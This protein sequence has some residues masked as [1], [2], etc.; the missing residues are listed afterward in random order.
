VSMPFIARGWRTPTL[1]VT[2]ATA[3]PW[4]QVVPVLGI[5]L[6][7]LLGCYWQTVV[8]MAAVWWRSETY[9]HGM[10]VFPISLYM[11]WKRRHTLTQLEP[12]PSPL[13]VV[14]LALAC[15]GWLAA[16]TA[17]VLVV[18]QFA[19]VTMLLALIYTLLGWQLSWAIAFPLAYLYFAVPAGEFLTPPLQ[20]FTALFAVKLLRLT[21]L[22]VFWEGYRISIPTGEFEV[23][24]A[25]S[26]LRYLIASLAL[27]CLYAYLTYRSLWRR[28]AF[29]AL[30]IVVPIIANGV[31]AYGIVMIAYLSN[32]RLATGVDHIIYGWLFFGLVV[33]LMFWIGSF[34][35]EPDRRPVLEAAAAETQPGARRADAGVSSGKFISAAAASLLVA[36]LGPAGE[37]WLNAD[38]AQTEAVVLP[39]PAATPPWSGPSA[40]DDDWQ[41]VFTGADAI[42]QRVYHLENRPVHLYI[43]FYRYQ[44]PNAK[45]VTTAN[46][47]YDGKRWFYAGERFR[48]VP[49]ASGR[50]QLVETRVSS[51][52]RRRLIWHWYWVAGRTTTSPV[53]TKM[54]EA[55]DRLG[56]KHQ[57]SALVAVAADYESSPAEAEALLTRFLD[58]MAGGI[59][60]TLSRQ[61]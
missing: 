6:L 37:A 28:L 11:I 58:S 46:T 48:T 42:L 15:L 25:C 20:N 55:W 56:S 39:A 60:T 24:E 33:L 27:G 59:E 7:I 34:W 51:G 8:S 22:P 52:T 32:G 21:G 12:R 9:A 50:Q 40:G 45:L 29:I 4:Y 36:A 26:G 18:Q 3:G 17:D 54:L 44:H 10:L 30:A 19:L 41:P 35:R 16:A 14:L 53:L 31:R 5:S 2:V 57:G 23:A 43:A 38:L 13:G 61:P 47:L 49:L 1:A